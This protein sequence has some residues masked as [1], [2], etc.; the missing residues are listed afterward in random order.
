MVRG[1]TAG[2]SVAGGPAGVAGGCSGLC[3]LRPTQD[4]VR[5]KKSSSQS[6]LA[7]KAA[8]KVSQ[9]K[10]KVK[11][12]GLPAGISPFRRKEPSPGSRIQKKLSRAKSA[13]AAASTKYPQQDLASRET[14]H[15]KATPSAGAAGAGTGVGQ[16]TGQGCGATA[17]LGPLGTQS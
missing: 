9:L 3:C 15:F 13:K 17:Q 11:S 8:H 1:R 2:Q 4:K 12:K 16:G 5:C 6:K 7:A 14:A 10:Q